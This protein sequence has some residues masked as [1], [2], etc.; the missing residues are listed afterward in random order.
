MDT[1][2]ATDEFLADDCETWEPC[3]SAA[4]FIVGQKYD[5]V[6]FQPMRRREDRPNI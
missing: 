2:T 3:T 1:V 6:F 5:P 4:R